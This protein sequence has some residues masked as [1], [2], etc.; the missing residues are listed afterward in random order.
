MG[1]A[2]ARVSDMRDPDTL[3]VVSELWT[4]YDGQE[5]YGDWQYD[6]GTVTD[7]TAYSSGL[8][9]MAAGEG[10]EYFRGNHLG[11]TRLMNDL[12]AP[13]QVTRSRSTSRKCGLTVTGATA[14][15]GSDSSR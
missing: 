2:S 1:P 12:P 15:S 10:P 14:R 11:T 4:D 9:Q 3:A 7:V 6:G 13:S 5:Y 8:F